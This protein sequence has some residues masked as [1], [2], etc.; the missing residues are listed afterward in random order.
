MGDIQ[1]DVA[2]ERRSGFKPNPRKEGP[3][4]SCHHIST[5]S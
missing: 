1:A 2:Y 4:G 5:R 3:E